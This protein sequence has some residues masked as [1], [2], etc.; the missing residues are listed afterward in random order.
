[1]FR[2]TALAVG[3]ML[4]A[5]C[6]TASPGPSTT[7]RATSTG[8]SSATASPTTTTEEQP[9]TFPLAVVTG[10][11]NLK[12]TI[13]VKELGALA[14]RGELVIPC[15]VEV[16]EPALTS[17]ASCVQADEIPATVKKGQKRIALLPPGLV[18][19]A[20]K[21]LPIA[22]KGP[23]GMFGVDLF[24]DAKARA[25][26]YPVLATA[27]PGA[28][29]EPSWTAYDKSEI[30]TM[31]NLGSL[32]ADRGGATQAVARGKGW[33]WVF[34]GGTAEYAGK[35]VVD[36]PNREPYRAVQPRDTGND[37]AFAQ[38]IKRSDVAIADHECPV[39]ADENWKPQLGRTLVF[40]V[41]EKVLPHW[42]DTLG[43][44]VV[45][46][47]ANHMSD[48]G[49]PGI[50]STLRLMDEYKIPRTGLG[51]NLDEALEPAYAEVAG[52]KLG[53]VSFND[54][55]GVA[56]ADSDTA[57]VPWI[58][59]KNIEAGVSRAR[60]GG[61]DLVICNPQWWGGAEYHNDLWPTQAKQVGWFDKAGCDHVIGSGTHVAGPLLLRQRGDDASV[62]L[63]SPGNHYFGQGWWQETQE[64]VILD[65][66]FRGKTLV[67]VRM[68]PTVMINEA[69]PALLDPQ[70]D[71]HYVL[72]RVWKYSAVD[73]AR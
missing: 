57:G 59:Q 36:P 55:S 15:G 27:E 30:W 32:C 12:S 63:V 71:G 18:E 17:D 11:T 51:M 45:Y 9:T 69:R 68:H 13:T 20:T 70:G 14:N 5:A 31:T 6:T 22:G 8:T 73:G 60:K 65:L 35:A 52:L 44:D 64:G 54:V 40:S 58:T 16:T 66:T 24:G 33:G 50:R 53:F 48:K 56:S 23:F 28:R 2:G 1:M 46:L 47:A 38:V 61:A 72:E 62:V 29:L 21:V 25:M 26:D 34:G 37:G 3:V 49:V 19:P 67:N 41:P 10:L 4:V 39:I 42:R 7:A 43:L